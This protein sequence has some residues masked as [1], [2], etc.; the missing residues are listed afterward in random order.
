MLPLFMIARL[1]DGFY[2]FIDQWLPL[3]EMTMV[4]APPKL[5]GLFKSQ[6][7]ASG[8]EIRRDEPVELHCQS[9]EYPDATFLVYWPLGSDRIHMLVPTKFA[10][11]RA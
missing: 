8:I 9:E 6:A 1:A 4:E 7:V 10:A 11:G 5:E 2:P 3:S